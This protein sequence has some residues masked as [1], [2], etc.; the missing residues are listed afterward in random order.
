ME[1]QLHEGWMNPKQCFCHFQI[2]DLKKWARKRY[3]EH[4]STVELLSL[5][6]DSHEREIISAVA[7][8]DVDEQTMLKMMGDVNMPEHHIL[9]CLAHLR[10]IV[11][12]ECR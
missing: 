12:E 10:K 9:H 7:L 11:D 5:T 8:L 3:C 2:D 1:I 6:E 4:Y